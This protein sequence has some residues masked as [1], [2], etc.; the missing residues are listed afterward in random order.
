[1]NTSASPLKVAVSSDGSRPG[2]SINAPNPVVLYVIAFQ[3]CLLTIHYRPIIHIHAVLRKL[4]TEIV[5]P[6]SNWLTYALL[7]NVICEFG[8]QLR[9]VEAEVDGIDEQVMFL[10]DHRRSQTEFKA[11]LRQMKRA[12]GSLNHLE[13]LLSPKIK[14]L[15][16]LRAHVPGKEQ[17][18]GLYVRDVEDKLNGLVDD[19][20]RTEDTLKRAHPIYLAWIQ[21]EQAEIGNEANVQMKRLSV[22]AAL[23]TPIVIISSLWGMNVIVPFQ[24]ISGS[25]A[26]L[27]LLGPFFGLILFGCIATVLVWVVGIRYK[28]F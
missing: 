3:D 28:C 16:A 11:I 2:S 24:S 9:R 17:A 12:L 18:S 27:S 8:P 20:S 15:T 13:R 21:I 4:A 25:M 19:I 22:F 1:M 5:Q 26:Q 7:E 14:L 10:D 23:G 6:S